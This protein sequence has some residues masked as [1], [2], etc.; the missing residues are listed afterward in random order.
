VGA[1]SPCVQHQVRERA[2]I[3]PES[4][5][6]LSLDD[7]TAA[8]LSIPG[9]RM[10]CSIALPGIIHIYKSIQPLGCPHAVN[11][12]RVWVLELTGELLASPSELLASP[13]ELLASPSELLGSLSPGARPARRDKRPA[14]DKRPSHVVPCLSVSTTVACGR[15]LCTTHSPSSGLAPSHRRLHSSQHHLTLRRASRVPLTKHLD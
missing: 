6:Q 14:R 13:S 1:V 9:L 4:C 7:A 10:L 8:G 3:R 2:R 15:T 12:Y 11:P 5:R